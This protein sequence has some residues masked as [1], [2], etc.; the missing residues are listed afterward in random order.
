[1]A[2]A[3]DTLTIYGD[4]LKTYERDELIRNIPDRVRFLKTLKG[5][6]KKLTIGGKALTVT[7]ATKTGRGWGM[8]ALGEG[9]DY[10]A[11][12]TASFDAY[13]ASLAH[14]SYTGAVSGHLQ[15]AG[16]KP[17]FSFA[18]RAAMETRE[19]VSRMAEKHLGISIMLDGTAVLG[20][21]SNVSSDTL[22]IT[23]ANMGWFEK[24]MR[25]TVRDSASGGSEQLTS[26]QPASGTIT[27]V[28]KV[29]N[30]IT[31]ADAT[32]AAA[33][34]YVAWY[35]LYGQTVIQGIQS[36]ND[37]S[38][39]VQG[40]NRATAGNEHAQAWEQ[41]GAGAALSET[42]VLELNDTVWKHAPG[43]DDVYPDVFLTDT[44]SARWLAASMAGR[45]RF[46]DQTKMVGGYK[47]EEFI[48][49]N[50]RRPIVN[51]PLCKPGDFHA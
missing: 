47:C 2:Y 20:Q 38:G 42:M 10:A 25:L 16:G 39:T 36:L 28:D 21:I 14:Y 18:A 29:G 12:G 46:S 24:N 45:H 8:N 50:G 44:D 30:T 6:G 41:S 31:V 22:T 32:G 17:D 15:A 26:A 49:G 48:T 34:D 7:W 13:T 23:G 33:N 3:G 40:V 4:A 27:A 19:E 43:E 9:G 51:D 11:E 5:N 35:G 37:S 1:M